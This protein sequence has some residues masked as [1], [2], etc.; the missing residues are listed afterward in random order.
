MMMCRERERARAKREGKKGQNDLVKILVGGILRS[1]GKVQSRVWG[2]FSGLV[3]DGFKQ[4]IWS[5]IV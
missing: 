1:K 4:E 5:Q 3:C 2:G